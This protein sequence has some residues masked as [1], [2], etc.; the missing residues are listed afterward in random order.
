MWRSYF[1]AL[2]ATAVLAVCITSMQG[3]ELPLIHEGYES[4]SDRAAGHVRS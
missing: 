2:V 4:L 1:C 3:S